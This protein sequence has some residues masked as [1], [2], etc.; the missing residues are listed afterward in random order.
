MAPEV[1]KGLGAGK[2]SDVWSLGCCI[3][4]MLTGQPPWI[5]HGT[6]ARHIMKVIQEIETQHLDSIFPKNI[7][8]VLTHF[9][10][11]CFILDVTQRITIE[12]LFEH[13]FVSVPDEDN[14]AD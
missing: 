8:S 12:E 4:E 11:Y 10:K 1:V 14:V 5:Q 7:S 3:I 2:P 6:D 9:L 13:P